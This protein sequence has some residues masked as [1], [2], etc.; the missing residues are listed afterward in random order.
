MLKLSKDKRFANRKITVLFD[1]FTIRRS[2]LWAK[3]PNIRGHQ[4]VKNIA[5]VLDFGLTFIRRDEKFESVKEKSI[6]VK[7]C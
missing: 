4:R 2:Q 5:V 7:R 3:L 6:E 1:V